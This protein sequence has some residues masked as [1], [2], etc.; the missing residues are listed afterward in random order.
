MPEAKILVVDDVEQNRNL[1]RR[2]LERL[3][4][5]VAEA[6]SGMRALQMM[7]EDMPDIVLLDFMMPQMSGVE[8]LH[9][10]R[11]EWKITNLPIIMQTARAEGEAV[12]EALAAGADDYVTK[13]IDFEAL[14]ARIEAQLQKSAKSQQLIKSHDSRDEEAIMNAMT[15]EAMR[16]ELAQEIERRKKAEA[17]AHNAG[18]I[19]PQKIAESNAREALED[20]K[21]MLE[22]TIQLAAKANLVPAAD[23]M[24][25]LATLDRAGDELRKAG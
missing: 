6:E 9:V 23:L 11:S 19:S 20:A 4:Y 17:S 3:G 25:I 21:R 1:V 24:T 16:E 18:G 12:S 15:L 8:V 10:I 5:H 22:N 7:Q 13:P 14:R 2:R